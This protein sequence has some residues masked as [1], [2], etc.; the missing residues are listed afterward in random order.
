[1]TTRLLIPVDTDQSHPALLT[2]SVHFQQAIRHLLH[3]QP[4]REHPPQFLRLSLGKKRTLQLIE[5]E[6]ALQ[7]V[8]PGQIV[9]SN[10]LCSEILKLA[11]SGHFDLIV[12]GTRTGPSSHFSLRRSVANY[13]IR[14][15]P[16]PVLTVPG[17]APSR[18]VIR[19]VLL[20]HDFSEQATH[21]QQA[22]RQFLPDARVVQLHVID[23][24]SLTT[25][26]PVPGTKAGSLTEQFRARNQAWRR[27][28]RRRM[29]ALNGGVIIE[30]SLIPTVMERATSGEYDLIALGASPRYWLSQVVQDS[31]IAKLLRDQ[32]MPLLT[33]PTF[34]P[35]IG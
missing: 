6:E 20:L 14:S 19:R 11:G 2:A 3:I 28:A 23:P 21:A 34:I 32:P 26:F 15:S 22:V 17:S 31:L 10:Q 27:E 33:A 16:I 8:G 5:I 12:M 13:V 4:R 7:R 9:T 30:G 35:A 18:Q 25:P 1:M 24:G 29:D